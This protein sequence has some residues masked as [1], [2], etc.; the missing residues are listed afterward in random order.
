[1]NSNF[2]QRSITGSIFVSAVIAATMFSEFSFFILLFV[3]N[4]LC[5]LEFYE[6]VLPDKRWLE[7]YLGIICG[8]VIFIMFAM[9]FSADLSLAWYYNLI[10]IFMFMFIIKLFER[11]HNE[12]S[13]LA[14]QILG[15]LYITM[16][17]VIYHPKKL[18]KAALAGQF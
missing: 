10:P 12:F 5:L 15:L 11:T 14:F 16:P 3:I 7:K 1:M 8:S 9:I 17:I 4:F 18:G 6:L 2:V 13:T